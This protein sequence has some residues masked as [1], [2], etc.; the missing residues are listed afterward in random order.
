MQSS[1]DDKARRAVAHVLHHFFDA[2]WYDH[3]ERPLEI[4]E[5]DKFIDRAAQ[6]IQE[7]TNFIVN[8]ERQTEL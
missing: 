2:A 6:P 5:A 1:E 8:C 3:D 7:A 4:G